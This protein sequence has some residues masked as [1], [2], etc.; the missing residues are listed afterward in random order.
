MPVKGK[1]SF[2]RMR[3]VSRIGWLMLG[4]CWLYM[5]DWYLA[6][7]AGASGSHVIPL[8]H[9]CAHPRIIF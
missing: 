6:K 2:A 7:S 5:V 9:A 4:Y 3:V 1:G 8:A